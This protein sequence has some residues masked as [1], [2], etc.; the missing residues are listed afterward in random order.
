MVDGRREKAGLKKAAFPGYDKTGQEPWVSHWT[1]HR[2]PQEA[3]LP[4]SLREPEL[5]CR[6]ASQA[7]GQSS[8][9]P[10]GHEVVQGGQ[11]RIWHLAREARRDGLIL[12]SPSS[13]G[14]GS[15]IRYSCL[16]GTCLSASD[17]RAAQSPHTRGTISLPGGQRNR[18]HC[19]SCM[20]VLIQGKSNAARGTS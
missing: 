18:C 1:G 6:T 2:R 12:G 14:S 7:I 10:R 19:P 4:P 3:P 17:N 20:Y 8:T 16:S 15:P 13:T 9:G 5:G 11:I